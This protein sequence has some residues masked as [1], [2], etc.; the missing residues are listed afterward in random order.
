M[1]TGAAP[2]LDLRNP[3]A[4]KMIEAYSLF[5]KCQSVRD[6]PGKDIRVEH[7]NNS[8]DGTQRNR[9]PEYEA[10]DNP[11][12][13]DLLRGCGSNCD[14][15]RVYHFSHHSTG[16]ISRAHQNGVDAE[17]LRSNPLQAAKQRI[18]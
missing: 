17:L 9:V 16:A 1:A 18:G 3:P 14:R 8:D 2:V 10:K 11:F 6:Q 13:A 15:L 5:H 4:R 7:H 12:I